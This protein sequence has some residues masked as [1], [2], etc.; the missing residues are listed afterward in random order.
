[1]TSSTITIDLP[2]RPTLCSE[3]APAHEGNCYAAW[4][5]HADPG[6]RLGGRR[7]EWRKSETDSNNGREP[8]RGVQLFFPIVWRC[9]APSHTM[10]PEEL[11]ADF[12]HNLP[13]IWQ[14]FTDT[15]AN[16][17]LKKFDRTIANLHAFEP[18]R[19]PDRVVEKG[20][21][22]L[23][24]VTREDLDRARKA[25]HARRRPPPRY[26]LALEEIDRLVFMLLDACHRDPKV[27]LRGILPDPD[28]MKYLAK[29]NPKWTVIE[30]ETQG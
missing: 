15:V 28:R 14:R 25:S 21:L 2:H 10:T 13:L 18:L 30:Q 9:H 16:P 6:H 3:I 24:Q 22:F 29:S 17:R 26:L 1:M 27:F 20:A 12:L 19:Y 5:Q 4:A 8:D 7:S 11:T 23:F